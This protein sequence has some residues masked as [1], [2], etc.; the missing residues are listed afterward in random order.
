M[1]RIS[2]NTTWEQYDEDMLTHLEACGLDH[3]WNSDD[4]PSDD[5]PDFYPDAKT[6]AEIVAEVVPNA[7]YRAEVAGLRAP[8]CVY[9]PLT[10]LS[11]FT[12]CSYTL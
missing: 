2:R 8:E 7:A 4:A 6:A 3:G 12:C 9:C 5:E 1:P 11:H 10:G